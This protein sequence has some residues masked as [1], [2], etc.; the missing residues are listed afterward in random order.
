MSGAWIS[1]LTVLEPYRPIF[2][3]AALGALVLAWRRTLEPSEI[4]K[5]ACHNF[6]LNAA[7]ACGFK[8]AFVRR[9]S[10]WGTEDPPDPVPHADCNIVVD[11]FAALAE[12]WA[13]EPG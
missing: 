1:N 5:V 9:P 10:E 4:L 3:G 6:D 2:V 7:R 8:T 11:G 13:S 12:N